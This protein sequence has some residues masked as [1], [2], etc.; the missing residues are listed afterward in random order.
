MSLTF[1]VSNGYRFCYTTFEVK[2]VSFYDSYENWNDFTNLRINRFLNAIAL[3]VFSV[4]QMFCTEDKT[5]HTSQLGEA[6]PLGI[7]FKNF[8]GYPNEL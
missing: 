1:D 8:L 4:P 3:T 2:V 7:N 5:L 6:L